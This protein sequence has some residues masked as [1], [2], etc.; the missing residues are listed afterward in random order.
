VLHRLTDHQKSVIQKFGFNCLLAFAKTD[1]PS[2]FIRW[3]VSCVDPDSSQIIVDDKIINIF[4]DSFHFVLGLPNCGDELV[5]DRHG[6]ID[7]I[8]SLFHLSE[9][10]HITFFGEKLKSTEPLSDQEIFVCFMQIATSCFLCPTANVYLDTKY[11]QQLGDFERARSF[12]VC[13]L[14]YKHFILGISKTLKFIKTKG[15]KP[16]SFDFCSYA[17]AVSMTVSFLN[18]MSFVFF[19]FVIFVYICALKL[20]LGV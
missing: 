16:K 17:L 19:Y 4:K 18:F 13:Q 1:I 3:L 2:A 6:G 8:M 15:R 5:E 14:V 9:V 12:D 20:F 10:P 7:F 11:I